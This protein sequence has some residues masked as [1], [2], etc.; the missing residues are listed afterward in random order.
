MATIVDVLNF[1]FKYKNNEIII[2]IDDEKVPW[3]YRKQI[4]DMLGYSNATVASHHI[5]DINMTTYEK[6][7]D[8]TDKKYNLQFH[9]V[10]INESGLYDMLRNINTPLA[11]KFK[12]WLYEEVLPEIRKTGKYELDKKNKAELDKVNERLKSYEHKEKTVMDEL[13]SRD[14]RIET[15]EFNQKKNKY[16]DGGYIYVMK[17]SNAHDVPEDEDQLLKSG[18]T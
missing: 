1:V 8:Y 11:R 4:T 2:I 7:K 10:M 12:F 14:K 13:K 18:K 3:F 15:L 6:I 16:P 5:E 17:P 9:C